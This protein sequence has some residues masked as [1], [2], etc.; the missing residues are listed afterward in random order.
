[1]R[2]IDRCNLT[3]LLESGQEDTAEFLADNKVE[4]VASL[5]CYL[6]ENVDSQR[7]EGVY[8]G[9]LRPCAC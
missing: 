5:P 2:V 7:G 8:E 1:M 4:I 3:V 6:K 9:S